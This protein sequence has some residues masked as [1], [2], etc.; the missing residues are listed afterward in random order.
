MAQVIEECKEFVKKHLSMMSETKKMLK[1]FAADKEL[2]ME[3]NT[4]YVCES[5]IKF[6]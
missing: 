2:Y 6:E 1:K 4:N 5:L 3:E